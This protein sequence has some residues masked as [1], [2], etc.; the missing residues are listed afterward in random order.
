M[1]ILD[2]TDKLCLF[3]LYQDVQ[4][5]DKE[6]NQVLFTDSFYG[7]SSCGLIDTDNR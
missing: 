6:S 2:E 3:Y 5:L 7:D 4:L 1:I